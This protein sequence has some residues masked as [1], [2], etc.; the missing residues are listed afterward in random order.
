[1]ETND[2]AKSKPKTS[3]KIAILDTKAKTETN[4]KAETETF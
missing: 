3:L 2:G 1:M 4:T